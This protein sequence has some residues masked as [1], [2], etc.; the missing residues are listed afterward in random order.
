MTNLTK[1]LSRIDPTEGFVQYVNTVKPYHSKI[2]DVLLEYVYTDP[3]R[4]TVKEKWKLD[5]LLKRPKSNIVYSCGYGYRWDPTGVDSPDAFPAATITVATPQL[6]NSLSNSFLVQVPTPTPYGV[7]VT[8]T[9]SNQLAFTRTFNIVAVNPANQTITVTGD[10]TA[11]DHFSVND[12]IYVTDNTGAGTNGMYTVVGTS[13][14]GTTSILTVEQ[15]VSLL[16]TISGKVHFVLSFNEIP[17]WPSGTTV[18][19]ASSG[20]IPAPLTTSIEYHFIPTDNVGYFNLATTRYP[21]TWEDFVDLTTLGSGNISVTRTEPFVPGDPIAVY[22]SANAWNDGSY[23][24]KRVV[25]EAPNTFRVYVMQ[26]VNKMTPIGVTV[27]GRLTL[28]VQPYNT[29]AYCDLA[30]APDLHAET[31]ISE[32]LSFSFDIVF[33]ESV[34][35][36]VAEVSPDSSPVGDMI[37]SNGYDVQVYDLGGYD[38]ID[39][40]NL[41]MVPPPP[42]APSPSPSPPPPPPAPPKAD[43]PV[44]ASSFAGTP[45][46]KIW[47]SA[48]EVGPGWLSTASMPHNAAYGYD[49]V[50]YWSQMQQDYFTLTPSGVAEIPWDNGYTFGM[51]AVMPQTIRTDGYFEVDFTIESLDNGDANAW[52][53]TMCASPTITDSSNRELT[54]FSNPPDIF[55]DMEFWP[56]ATLGLHFFYSLYSSD[57]GFQQNTLVGLEPT[58]GHKY[59]LRAD[60]KIDRVSWLMT[61]LTSNTTV[62]L[63]EVVMPALG[64]SDINDYQNAVWYCSYNEGT[65]ATNSADPGI[66]QDYTQTIVQYQHVEVG[67]H[68]TSAV[69]VVPP[70]PDPQL[71]QHNVFYAAIRGGYDQTVFA[72]VDGA[73]WNRYQGPSF[74]VPRLLPN[75]TGGLLAWADEVSVSTS[76]TGYGNWTEHP[77]AFNTSA[78]VQNDQLALNDWCV[79]ADKIVAMVY[80]LGSPNQGRSYASY[81]TNGGATW[82]SID[83]GSSLFTTVAYGGGKYVAIGSDTQSATSTDGITWTTHTGVPSPTSG[84]G[85]GHWV[86]I[87]YAGG[88]FVAISS[89]NNVLNTWQN[90]IM[91]SSDGITWTVRSIPASLSG[92]GTFLKSIAYDEVHGKYLIRGAWGH[93]DS[94]TLQLSSGHLLLTSPDGVTWTDNTPVVL[95][96]DPSG[97]V[98]GLVVAGNG[99]IVTCVQ[100]TVYYSSDGGVTWAQTSIPRDDPSSYVDDLVFSS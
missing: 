95:A 93:Q 76:P 43:Y 2:L 39:L 42:P 3:V 9:K 17:Y 37:L 60:F 68:N 81:S 34:S 99:I 100:L 38:G 16:A 30:Q 92:K 63:S 15:P 21:A 59:H 22:G 5:I 13:T 87:I 88:K 72:S 18:K 94:Q 25:K 53:I 31:F 32:K 27:D 89:N 61:D 51:P 64:F 45:G 36:K 33:K 66:S 98:G 48:V 97:D 11:F 41:S 69:S 52:W 70:S 20:V 26:R 10:V 67:A 80:K 62:V 85:S 58:A 44:F 65:Y 55:F 7:V 6:N 19:V 14:D 75:G 71:S 35:T 46:Q 4:T 56:D 54:T 12:S 74:F 49:T 96:N 1:A 40:V 86:D 77:F 28:A 29:P 84:F 23:N 50:M 78:A 73:N 57:G 47:N 24:V 82:T 90:Q 79:G 8:D 83:L 91:T